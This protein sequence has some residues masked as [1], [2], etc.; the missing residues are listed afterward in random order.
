MEQPTPIIDAIDAVATHLGATAEQAWAEI[1]SGAFYGRLSLEGIDDKGR[2]C[3]VERHWI[4]YIERW[5]ND[6]PSLGSLTDN[7]ARMSDMPNRDSGSMIAFDRER[8][9]RDRRADKSDGREPRSVPPMRVR[10]LMAE[11]TQLGQMWA[12]AEN[13]LKRLD[14]RTPSAMLISLGAAVEPDNR[15]M[16]VIE[17]AWQAGEITLFGRRPNGSMWEPIVQYFGLEIIWHASAPRGDYYA[18]ARAQPK[19]LLGSDFYKHRWEELLI[20]A[21]DL[22]RLQQPAETL[23]T[24]DPQL[25][26]TLEAVCRWQHQRKPDPAELKRLPEALA[27]FRRSVD[28]LMRHRHGPDVPAD[29]AEDEYNRARDHIDGEL[30]QSLARGEFAAFLETHY[31]LEVMSDGE[32]WLNADGSPTP[33]GGRALITGAAPSARANNGPVV[34][35][36]KVSR[37]E[38]E[39]F[40]G[41]CLV[42]L[43]LAAPASAADTEAPVAVAG[44]LS[45]GPKGGEQNVDQLAWKIAERLLKSD[46]ARARG[47]GRLMSLARQVNQELAKGGHKRQDDS[48][49]KAIGP[50]LREWERKNPDK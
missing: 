30:L 43:G 20:P 6:D 29:V 25:R 2:P 9:F 42:K 1:K 40:A 24:G 48:I 16:D 37:S 10:E 23:H 38:F 28:K 8:A 44:V 31:G 3:S 26:D 49:R 21:A 41:A 17:S 27:D 11:G 35:I 5:G 32:F 14:W 45:P 50:S 22:A 34:G 46:Q 47:H 12:P 19:N 4:P 39:R 36:V 15:L 13:H 7:Q 18:E 33:Q